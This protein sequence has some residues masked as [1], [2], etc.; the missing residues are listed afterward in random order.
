MA[1]TLALLLSG[2]SDVGTE[3]AEHDRGTQKHEPTSQPA[4]GAQAHND[5]D[6]EFAGGMIPHHEQAVAMSDIVL[7]KQGIEPRV[8]ELA[9]QIKAAQGPEI[10]TMQ[11]WLTQWGAPVASGH[12][13][14]DMGGDPA[15]QKAMGMMTEQELEQLRQAQGAEASRLFLNGMI[16]HHEGAVRMAQTE[17]DTGQAEEAVHLAH[18]IIETQQREIDTMKAILASL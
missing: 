1:T 14:H 4:D 6:V 13:G 10:A 17:V 9:N 15:A 16:A 11:Q 2:C 3:S 5:A 18:E 7:A 12:D 8:T